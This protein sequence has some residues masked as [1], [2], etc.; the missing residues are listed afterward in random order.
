[1]GVKPK[2]YVQPWVMTKPDMQMQ[3]FHEMNGPQTYKP[4]MVDRPMAPGPELKAAQ[5]FAA[6][7]HKEE[8]AR[9]LWP[10]SPPY[11]PEGDVRDHRALLAIPVPL[12][13][14]PYALVSP[15]LIGDT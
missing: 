12:A 2:D 15:P 5:L 4:M 8:E 3:G 14:S 6:Q 1:M 10:A 7:P 11:N 9:F 13:T